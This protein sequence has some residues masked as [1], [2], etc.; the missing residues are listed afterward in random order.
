[1]HA[2]KTRNSFFTKVFHVLL[3]VFISCFGIAILS[4]ITVQYPLAGTILFLCSLFFLMSHWNEISGRQFSFGLFLLSLVIHLGVVLLLNTP[5]ESD[6]ALQYEASQQF[7]RGDYS[8]QDTVYFQRWG[9]QTG[10]VI[11]QGTLLKL[12]N[13][14][15]FLRL[16]NCVVSAGTNVLVYCIARD[17]FEERAARTASL[18]YTFFLF[19]ATLVTVLC[20]NIPA[21]FFL[22][23]CLYLVMGK[24]FERCHR[25]LIYALAGASLALANALRPDAPL[26]LVPLLVYFVFRFL[27][28]A[29][30][31]NFFHYLKRFAALV[32]TFLVLSAGMSGLVKVTGVNSAGLS[33]N[34]PLWGLVIGTNTEWKGVYNNED[35]QVIS[36]KESAGLSRSQAELKVIQEHLQVSPAKLLELAICKI[37]ILWWE[38]GL[39]WSM[40]NLK[41][42]TPDLF[43]LLEDV[44]GA[45]FTSALFLAGV[46]AFSLFRRPKDNLKLYLL[47]FVIFATCCVYL[48]L[49]VQPRYAYVG[50]VS[51]FILM[52]G[53]VQAISSC[54]TDIKE[55]MNT[56][57]Q[58]NRPV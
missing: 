31:K 57:L 8:F 46:G 51:V 33:N 10:L 52:A 29:N 2:M 50:Q 30:W 5:I 47:P 37:K 56:L 9:Y 6:F 18:A 28:K 24:S 1:M 45:M 23:L 41:Q 14:P 40:G 34:D 53:G 54:W 3:F 44:D 17:Y 19:P 48:F 25:V 11:W 12:W 43:S 32:L 13:S 4:T 15:V 35:G 42:E 38:R 27:S 21:T 16:I 20:N 55:R 58:I 36:Q 39:G 22:Y 26:V 7:A 49:E